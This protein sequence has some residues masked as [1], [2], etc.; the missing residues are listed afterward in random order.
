M[1]ETENATTEEP[2]A[3][4]MANAPETLPETPKEAA[5]VAGPVVEPIVKPT[6]VPEVEPPEETL[7]APEA[8]KPSEIVPSVEP[9]EVSEPV[10]E[11]L[12]TAQEPANPESESTQMGRNES[13]PENSPQKP[14]EPEK[15]EKPAQENTETPVTSSGE[16]LT[17]NIKNALREILLKAREKIQWRKR[18]KLE[19][20][21][22][23]IR[24]N[25][26]ISNDETEKLLHVSHATAT[27]YLKELVKSGKIKT[28]GKEGRAI[29]Y[30][31]N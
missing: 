26:S 16:I 19:K 30:V 31:A 27:R 1:P 13:I 7:S 11:A 29:A 24:K 4:V 15:P 20:I 9:T 12:E 22:E 23:Y 2:A 8:A 18:R 25:G 28:N 5:A 10:S 3:T 6:K 14:A 17:K 21:M